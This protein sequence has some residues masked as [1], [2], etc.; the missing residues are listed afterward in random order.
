MDTK[1]RKTPVSDALF[2]SPDPK[3]APGA[4]ASGKKRLRTRVINFKGILKNFCR[5]FP[6]VNFGL[7]LT[8][9]FQP[10]F[11]LAEEGHQPASFFEQLFCNAK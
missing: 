11:G 2:S 1:E 4:A 9:T 7:Q 3:L 5:N 10:G 8:Q 6:S